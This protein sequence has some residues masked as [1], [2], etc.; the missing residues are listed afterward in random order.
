MKRLVGWGAALAGIY[1]ASGLYVV[2]GNEQAL[3]RRFGRADPA[4]VA[5]G[6]HFDLPWPFV[7]IERV[8]VHELRTITV[9]VAA[10]E[11]FDGAGFLRDVNLDR[12]G[13]FLTGDKNILNVQVGVQYA[14]ADPH[15]YYFGCQSPDTGLRLLAES[16]AAETIAQCGVDYVHPLGLNELQALLTQAV[17][18]AVERQPWGIAVDRV[19]IIGA[20]PVEVK[21]AFVDVSNARAEKVRMISQEESRRERLLAASRARVQQTLDRA[22]AD[23][24]ARVESARGSADRFLRVVS[25]FQSEAESGGQAAEEVRRAAM[26]RMLA[27]ALEGLLP[28]LAGKVLLDPTQPVDLTIFPPRDEPQ[29]DGRSRGERRGRE[30]RR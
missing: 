22:E 14:I 9:G 8:N 3:V 1:L 26:R 23:R 20:P 6:L 4:L 13:E 15:R 27:A 11:A 28:K 5:G 19:T 10:A 2:R 30:D 18:Q 12:Q 29:G 17:R 7:R 25:Q 16:L 24:L 21:A